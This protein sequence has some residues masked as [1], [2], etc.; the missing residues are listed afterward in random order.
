[1]RFHDGTPL[2][3]A[4]VIA[5]I[6]RIPNVPNNPNPY[7]PL[8]RSIDKA[9]AVDPLT[10][11]IHTKFADPILPSQLAGVFVVPAA[12]ARE[13]QTVDFRSGKSAI[14][15]GPYR[16][17]SWRPGERLELTRFDDHWAGRQPWDKVT[18]RL[19][20]N[21]A[22]R[23]VALRTGE[24]QVI[25]NVNPVHAELIERDPN[26]RLFKRP[27]VTIIY[28]ILDV[29]RD[30]TPMAVDRAGQ[31]LAANPLK[32]PRVRRAMSMAINRE[33]LAERV[34]DRLA[35]PA[36]QMVPEGLPGHSAA[37]PPATFD[38][39][40]ARRLLAEAGF[41]EGFGLTLSGPND[42]YLNDAKALEA[43][44]Q[45]LARLGLQ[46]KVAAEP[47]TVY[48]PKARVT[49][50]LEGLPY[51]AMLIGWSHSVGDSSGM[52]T[53]VLHS[54]DRQRGF[55]TGN[56]SG[57]R[58]ETYDALIRDAVGEI[59]PA[60]RRDK[61]AAA[62]DAT[63]RLLHVVPLYNPFVVTAARRGLASSARMDD[64]LLAMNVRPE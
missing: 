31:P 5:S 17:A 3:A 43:V 39:A 35:L 21:D 61:L 40:A 57:L 41:A 52:L 32:D 44:G 58:D 29:A 14:G 51:S 1:M 49:P 42:R 37:L 55:G 10:L 28:L 8:I 13:A 16:F 53:T 33:A 54:F 19:I 36:H 11:R 6:E 20:A 27:S 15:S 59:D 38:V 22:A 23:V 12:V 18:M 34:M 62:M 63:M 2:T 4:D 60:R 45:M 56:R 48:F 64:E 7:T 30:P 46:V 9:E 24:V 47:W 26:L 25:G 50:G